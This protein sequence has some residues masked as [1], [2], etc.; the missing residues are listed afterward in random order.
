MLALL[1]VAVLVGALI[2]T[3]VRGLRQVHRP[4]YKI[5]STY[6]IGQALEAKRPGAVGQLRDRV[7]R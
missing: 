4:G 7:R 1:I 2:V 5:E 3:D 6:T